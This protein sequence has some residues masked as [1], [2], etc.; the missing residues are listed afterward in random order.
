MHDRDGRAE[1][2]CHLDRRR[3]RLA[4]LGRSVDRDED[5]VEHQPATAGALPTVSSRGRIRAKYAI[6]YAAP[7]PTGARYSCRWT[8]LRLGCPIASH[9]TFG[10]WAASNAP[11]TARPISAPNSSTSPS[12]FVGRSNS[13]SAE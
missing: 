13:F 12:T 3:Q 2:L 1:A 6:A 10:C 9:C 5:P 11:Q 7:T 8:Q 4:A